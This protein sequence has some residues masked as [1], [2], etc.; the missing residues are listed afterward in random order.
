[1]NN[2]SETNYPLQ[3]ALEVCQRAGSLLLSYFRKTDLNLNRK[4]DRSL[5]SEADIA[6]DE[7]ITNAI[8]LQFPSDFILSEELSPSINTTTS[9]GWVIDPLDGTTR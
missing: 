9:T 1:M 4:A 3:F 8:Q 6:A 5:I 7:L 2:L